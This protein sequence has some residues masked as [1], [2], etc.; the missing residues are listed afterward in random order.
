[1][2]KTFYRSKYDWWLVLLMATVIVSVWYSAI[3]MSWA[4]VSF[5]CGGVTLLY[6][7]LSF[8]CWYVIEG[9][10]LVIYQLFRHTRIPVSNIKSLKKTTGYLATAGMSHIRVS[11]GLTSPNVLKTYG[12]LEISPNDRDKFIV[13]LVSLNP[14]I[15][16]LH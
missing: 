11:I 16:V 4:Y 3:G 14:K 7:G 5:V 1:M 10:D 12:P 2:D 15:E 13:Q 9:K 6:L 8:G